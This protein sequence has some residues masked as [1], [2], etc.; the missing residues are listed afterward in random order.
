MEV[1]PD[2]IYMKPNSAK[3]FRVI[4]SY[5]YCLL[6]IDLMNYEPFSYF[7]VRATHQYFDNIH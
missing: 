5:I 7:H 2:T 1:A 4:S 3:S 6:R